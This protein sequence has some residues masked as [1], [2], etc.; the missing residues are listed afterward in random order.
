MREGETAYGG[1][2]RP[3]DACESLWDKAAIHASLQHVCLI[4]AIANPKQCFQT[5]RAQS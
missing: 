5:V 2:R 3:T 1:A 4:P